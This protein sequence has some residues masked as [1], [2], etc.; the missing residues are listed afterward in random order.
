[1]EARTAMVTPL[2]Q[3]VAYGIVFALS[4][5]ITLVTAFAAFHILRGV[6]RRL[7]FMTGSSAV[8]APEKSSGKDEEVAPLV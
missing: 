7:A 2:E 8:A 4:G 5:M 6:I 1:M 3:V